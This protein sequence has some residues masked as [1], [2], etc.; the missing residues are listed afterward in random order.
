[1]EQEKQLA[2]GVEMQLGVLS[3]GSASYGRRST[4]GTEAVRA[5]VDRYVYGTRD[6]KE[7]LALF[8]EDALRRQAQQARPFT[9]G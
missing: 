3:P 7:Y 9:G 6:H 2:I 1:M 5:Y 4:R 8:G